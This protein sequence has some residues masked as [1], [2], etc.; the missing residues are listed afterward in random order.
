MI[1]MHID[2]DGVGMYKNVNRHLGVL[3]K[4]MVENNK[5]VN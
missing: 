3:E 2:F 4:C 1:L 5:R